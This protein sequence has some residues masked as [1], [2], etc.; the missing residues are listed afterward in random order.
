MARDALKNGADP[1]FI[2]GDYGRYPLA[3][4][5][6]SGR[7]DLVKLLVEAGAPLN[8]ENKYNRPLTFAAGGNLEIVKYLV[9][10]GADVNYESESEWTATMAANR[11]RHHHIINYLVGKGALSPQE[12]SR[13]S[14]QRRRA[15]YARE[16]R[17][18]KIMNALSVVGHGLD[19][20]NQG[21]YRSKGY[22]YDSKYKK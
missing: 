9:D 20:F 13:R 4:A 11:Y 22:K 6:S 1:G 8:K 15:R 5:C 16:R 2:F 21:Y 14:S 18:K 7:Y 12:L 17:I 10:K 19:G 3:I